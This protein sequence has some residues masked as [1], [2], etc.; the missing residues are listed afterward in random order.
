MLR[1]EEQVGDHVIKDIMVGTEAAELRSILQLSYPLENGIVRNW[2]DMYHLWDYTF[3]EKL[4][5]DPKEHKILLTEPPMN[6]KQ[7]RIKM[8]EA[9]LEHYGFEGF[10]IAIQAV[11]TLYAQGK[12]IIVFFIERRLIFTFYYYPFRFAYRCGC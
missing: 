4:Q 8:A 1:S 12:F 7:N 3:K 5:I 9:M 10:F 11:L 2:E 6:P